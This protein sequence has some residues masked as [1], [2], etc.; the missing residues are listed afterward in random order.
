ML[1]AGSDLLLWLYSY[2]LIA[3]ESTVRVQTPFN[4]SVVWAVTVGLIFAS[5]RRH[6]VLIYL[7]GSTYILALWLHQKESRWKTTGLVSW[8]EENRVL[9]WGREL[10]LCV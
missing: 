7:G 5:F 3:T 8:L 10:V 2:T 6:T 1:S 9:R 4:S